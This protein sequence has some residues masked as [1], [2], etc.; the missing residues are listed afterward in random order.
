[1]PKSLSSIWYHAHQKE[2]QKF[3]NQWVAVGPEGVL[4]HNSSLDEVIEKVPKDESDILY[5]FIRPPGPRIPRQ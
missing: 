2:L 5:A 4:A 3:V 1:M